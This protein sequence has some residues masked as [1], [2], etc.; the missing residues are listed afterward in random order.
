MKQTIRWLPTH[1]RARAF[2]WLAF[3]LGASLRLIPL[4]H[5]MP[6]GDGLSRLCESIEWAYQ[7]K[8]YGLGGQWPPLIMYLQGF[9]IRLGADAL[10]VAYGMGYLANVASLLLVYRLALVITGNYATALWSLLACSVYWLHITF[11]NTNFIEDLYNLLLISFILHVLKVAGQKNIRL[12]DMVTLSALMALM[13]LTRHEARL[14][15]IVSTIYLLWNREYRVFWV[16]AASG[17]LVTAYL[18]TEN[19]LMRGS[20]LADIESARRNFVVGAEIMGESSTIGERLYPLLRWFLPYHPSI[21]LIGAIV[22]GM[23]KSLCSKQA[24]FVILICGIPLIFILLSVFISPLVPYPRYFLPIVVPAMA[25]AGVGLTAVPIR[26]AAPLLVAIAALIQSGQW[27]H[28][29]SVKFGRYELVNILPVQRLH[30][31]QEVLREFIV[32]LPRNSRIYTLI[33]PRTSVNVSQIAVNMRR[34]D[35][36]PFASLHKY[37]DQYSAK[38]VIK[39]PTPETFQQ[40]DFVIVD[41]NHPDSQSVIQTVYRVGGKVVYERDSLI[42]FQVASDHDTNRF[43]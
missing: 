42:A 43:P 21:I 34:Y 11:V 12:L 7:P 8:W 6:A 1:S 31:R 32:A 10:W 15:W 18:L 13:L 40:V 27:Y 36:V 38:L 3:G 19:L 41:R 20:L 9:L 23:Y 22:W 33:A 16:V 2:F 14:I 24:H 35:L 30:P 5:P 26:G 28:S 37:Y 17:A 25:F 4:F 39:K 29:Q